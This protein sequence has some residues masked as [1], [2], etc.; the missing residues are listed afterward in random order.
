MAGSEWLR[1]NDEEGLAFL[2]K[3]QRLPPH[4]LFREI[5]R[6]AGLGLVHG[7]F[8]RPPWSENSTSVI[9]KPSRL[10]NL[11]LRKHLIDIRID[12]TKH[13]GSFLQ[14]TRMSRGMCNSFSTSLSGVS[15]GL[16]SCKMAPVRMQRTVR[17]AISDGD[18]QLLVVSTSHDAEGNDL[19]TMP[20]PTYFHSLALAQ[21]SARIN[22]LVSE[23]HP[24]ADP[25]HRY[26]HPCPLLSS[27]RLLNL[28]PDR[29]PCWCP[30]STRP[31]GAPL[32]RPRR[33][34]LT[35]PRIFSLSS[36]TGLWRRG[37]RRHSDSLWARRLD[38]LD[39]WRRLR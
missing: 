9:P 2:D 22:F 15:S 5:P 12:T 31:R 21:E 14:A 13:L 11:R 16:H 24:P 7:Q 36:P 35:R 33:Q 34:F 3:F 32:S 8:K 17:H 10:S 23:P 25:W 6:L 37:S 27:S 29:R 26:R 20:E 19:A 39:V 28:P 18:G 38:D 30:R 4:L 1:A